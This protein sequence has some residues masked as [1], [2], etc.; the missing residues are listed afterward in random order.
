MCS[1]KDLTIVN[2]YIVNYFVVVPL[3]KKSER[4]V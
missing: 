4:T 3:Q 1:A 2:Y